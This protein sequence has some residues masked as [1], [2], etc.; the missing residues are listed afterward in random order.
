M[1]AVD[2]FSQLKRLIL[3]HEQE[4]LERLQERVE[5]PATRAQDVAEVLAESFELN[6]DKTTE[7]AEAMRAPVQ[8]C[9]SD[10]VRDDPDD[11]AD[12]LFPVIGPAI[13]KAVRDS[14]SA[15]SEK[16]NQVLERSFST[17]G[18]KWRVESLRT[19]VPVAELILR[20]SFIYRVDQ[21]FVIQ[22]DSGLL[23]AH[24]ERDGITIQDS[25]A[26]SAM[27]TAIQEFVRDSFS[28][29]DDGT[30]LDTI[31][32][33]GEVVWLFH[34][35]HAIT[36]AIIH[37]QPPREMRH[38]FEQVTENI[39]RLHGEE[40]E[41]FDGT[42]APDQ[43][44]VTG[45][46]ALLQPLLE[47]ESLKRAKAEDSD[48]KRG[49]Y[50]LLGAA[51]IL[52]LMWFA[53]SVWERG[54][55]DELL[56]KFDSAAGIELIS[57]SNDKPYTIRAF[58]DPLAP[59]LKELLADTRLADSELEIEFVPFQSLAP[60]IVIKRL[61]GLFDV[62]DDIGFELQDTKL[63]VTGTVASDL[64]T[65][66]TGFPL[67]I[68]GIQQVDFVNAGANEDEIIGQLRRELSAP[69]ALRFTLDKAVAYLSGEA[70][71]PWIES[72][73]DKQ[74]T[75][76]GVE[77]L[78]LSALKP[79]ANSLIDHLRAASAAPELVDLSLDGEIVRAAGNGGERLRQKLTA[80]VDDIPYLTQVDFSRFVATEREEVR[81]LADLI[82]EQKFYFIR[83]DQLS[84]E[85]SQLARRLAD[86][87]QRLASLE[88]LL[89]EVKLEF[90]IRAFAD[91]AGTP[92]QHEAVR[93]LRADAIFDYLISNDVDAAN[94]KII[95]GQAEAADDES[96]RWRRAEINVI[97]R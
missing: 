85:S 13:R 79:E 11:F 68:L 76:P 39:H 94:I 60:E 50:V 77:S 65:R 74:I 41:R 18:L 83:N 35:P 8:R 82:N 90:E 32:L 21:A 6:A 2:E 56:A 23:I 51:L 7:L 33:G 37:G 43:H 52:L 96:L 81:A 89:N 48:S 10:A 54:K 4:S 92:E 84:D 29:S 88:K 22:R 75:T 42:K 97:V 91:S 31:R 12:A 45:V 26:V 46:S 15:L 36:A 78:D 87:I 47:S 9:I 58:R 64:R 24:V 67:S 61:R 59:S 49:L 66:L 95:S 93:E 17:Q 30:D 63:L 20:D 5:R 16:I 69:T 53:Y 38:S 25:D 57:V 80:L 3:G 55:L 72:L 34:G 40:L 1:A 73:N 71:Y 86:D 62:P 28:S 27:L 19:G 14:I 70:P 44:V